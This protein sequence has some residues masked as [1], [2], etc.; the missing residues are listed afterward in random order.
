MN[1]SAYGQVR[2]DASAWLEIAQNNVPVTYVRQWCWLSQN[3]ITRHALG[4]L[5]NE[6]LNISQKP[7]G[8][9]SKV[10]RLLPSYS[11]SSMIHVE[12]YGKFTKGSSIP[13]RSTVC[14]M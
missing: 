10:Q 11:V 9:Q 13:P 14:Q 2:I 7:I 12:I 6:C 4:R 1:A 5:R 8:Q 3:E